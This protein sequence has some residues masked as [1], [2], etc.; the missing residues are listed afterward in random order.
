MGA[1][2][3]SF[4]I[5]DQWFLALT[6]IPFELLENESF[7]K[8]ISGF[9]NIII[10]VSMPLTI[11]NLVYGIFDF[12]KEGRK[13]K[14]PIKNGK[15]IAKYKK[16][17]LERYRYLDFK[18]MGISDRVPLKLGL[19][20][21][22]VPLKARIE[23]PKGE[24]WNRELKLAGRK[25]SDEETD[26]MEKR[27]GEPAPIIKLMEQHDGLIVLGDPG[28]GKTT[29]LKYLTLELVEGRGHAV[30]LNGF[31][32]IL[33]PLS[34]YEDH[35]DMLLFDF[36]IDHYSKRFGA[37]IEGPLKKSLAQGK[38]LLLLDGLD[39]VRKI[40]QRKKV[41]DSVIVF[42]TDQREKGNKFI[43]TSRIVGYRDVRPVIKGL[44]ECTIVDFSSDEIH[45][46][47]EKWTLAIEQ[48]VKG[49]TGAAKRGA[50]KE[51]D[52]L[53]AAVN[54]NQSV[55]RL[56]S[57][58][59]L[60]TIL[61]LM[62]R[63][64]VTLPERRVE[65]YKQYVDTLLK[66]WNLARGLDASK[67]REVD[68]PETV[69]ILAQVALWMH[70]QSPQKGLVKQED[71]RRR[72]DS[73][74][75]KRHVEN[76]IW[77]AREFLKDVRKDASLLVERG[78]E[79]YGFLHLTF[80]EYLAAV[81][82]AQKG[83][84]SI[85]PVVEFI[86]KRRDDD[87][88]HE[89]IQLSIGYIGIIQRREKAAGAI[90]AKLMDREIGHSG[91]ALILAGKAI[92]DTGPSG[93]GHACYAE[94]KRK[95]RDMMLDHDTFQPNA[96]ARAGATLG[97]LGDDREGIGL[98]NALPDIKWVRVEK[99]PFF[100][101]SDP[102]V[103]KDARESDTPSFECDLIK[104]PFLISKYL[105]TVGQYQAFGNAGGYDRE[106]YWT[107]AGWQWRVA[108]KIVAPDVDHD[109]LQTP[110][111]PQVRVSWYEAMAFCSWL[112][113]ETGKP[114][115]LPSEA[116]WERAARHTDGRMY[117]YGNVF[118]KNKC[119]MGDTDIDHTSAAGMFPNGDA[120]CGASDMSGNVWE[121]CATK[122]LDNYEGY[123][124]KVDE[125][126]EGDETRVLRGGGFWNNGASVRC[127]FRN[128]S[129]PLNRNHSLGFRVVSPG[130]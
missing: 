53:I 58:P 81:A 26:F 125:N 110:N 123:P 56:A 84:E 40:D 87:N 66:H 69:E 6:L 113:E 120:E 106:K 119:N 42:F 28:A 101:G 35:T 67:T 18:G 102:A 129:Y 116:Q 65:L 76:P 1:S 32:P 95:L 126:P 59:L 45:A 33:F 25:V 37:H 63:Q 41:V 122:W 117:P 77:A 52:E 78:Y 39:E 17:L 71:L 91:D 21:M 2:V 55:G 9:L 16:Q 108:D 98:A 111:H 86:E 49:E 70:E 96:R 4:F 62:K 20:N 34:A 27:L 8:R 83:Q 112:S 121:W 57:N 15:A 73:V 30:N 64:G 12:I 75:K 68:L 82:V 7:N 43:I 104:E 5:K 19:I 100:M 36:I 103:D 94:I 48:N 90:L 47:V 10:L 23:I 11:L 79:E 88:W 13:K 109:L 14:P 46:F 72:L 74:H 22:Y 60:L 114:V 80:Q 92:M 97:M 89:V 29:L 44:G 24:T 93:V 31:L 99:G 105:V 124:D 118:D 61:A 38:T 54:R 107:K 130:R 128:W 115:A 127:A 50:K 51:K 85:D 3:L